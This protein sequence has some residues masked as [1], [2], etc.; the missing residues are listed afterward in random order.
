[1]LALLA[2]RAGGALPPVVHAGAHRWR[3]A[4]SGR[5]LGAPCQ[6][7]PASALVVAGDWCLDARTE[8][9]LVWMPRGVQGH[10]EPLGRVIECALVSGL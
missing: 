2:E 1:M 9:A 4:M 3:H 7:D 5:P 10:S 6:A 8:H